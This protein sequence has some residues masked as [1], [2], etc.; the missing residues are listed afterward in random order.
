MPNQL[1]PQQLF[2]ALEKCPRTEARC[3]AQHISSLRDALAD[4]QMV[5]AAVT[6]ALVK[7]SDWHDEPPTAEQLPEFVSLAFR[8]AE[9]VTPCR[10]D[11]RQSQAAAGDIGDDDLRDNP[12][13]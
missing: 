7:I 10:H 1:S 11:L 9:E 6:R 12:Y 13:L 2:D 3:L 5:L 4:S 8:R